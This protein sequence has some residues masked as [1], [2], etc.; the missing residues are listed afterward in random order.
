M[1]TASGSEVPLDS[2]EMKAI[3]ASVVQGVL[4][5]M[6]AAR[7][8][9][10][11]FTMHAVA[12]FA[13]AREGADPTVVGTVICDAAS[14]IEVSEDERDAYLDSM[15]EA[16]LAAAD[17]ILGPEREELASFLRRSLPAFL[18]RRQAQAASERPRETPD[19]TLN[20]TADDPPRGV[21]E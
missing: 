9:V 12:R 18:E 5:S 6:G 3:V 13:S 15:I 10:I 20:S 8:E 17:H 21:D 1:L 19:P 7:A 4:A 2:V 14:V 16:T 11:E